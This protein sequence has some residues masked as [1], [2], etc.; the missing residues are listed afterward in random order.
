MCI[1]IIFRAVDEFVEA[2]MDY[3]INGSQTG[4]N[5]LARSKRRPSKRR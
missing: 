2:L 4:E 3:D 1:F 5:L